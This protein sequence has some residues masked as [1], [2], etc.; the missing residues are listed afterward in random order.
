MNDSPYD[1][2][3]YTC[4]RPD[5][6]FTSGQGSWLTDQNG[7][8]YLDFVQGWAV[9]CLGHS[10]LA[11]T[12]AL[13]C[14]AEKMWNCS[15]AFYNA[16]QIALAQQ[17]TEASG[18]DKAFFAS[19]GAEANEGAIKLARKWGQENK[20]G[21]YKIITMEGSFHG[22]TLATMS[23]TGKPAFTDLFNPKVDGFV[24]VPF[25][26]LAACEQAIDDSVVAILLE[27]V[28]GEA[29]VIPASQAY[30]RGLSA[31]CQRHN[32]LLVFDEVQTG[33][34]R[35]GTVFA[36]DYY[37]VR[38]DVMTLGKGLGGGAPLAV[39]LARESVCCFEPGEQGST[40][41]GNAL[42]CAVGLE[43][44]KTVSR[45]EFLEQ[46][47]FSSS[48]LHHKLSSLFGEGSVR[49]MGLLLAVALELPV[50]NSVV[51][52]CF[53][54]GLLINAPNDQC[55]RFMPAL[56]VTLPEIE[57]MIEILSSAIDS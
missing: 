29:G 43:V 17:L 38:P 25:N 31:L 16:P 23:A 2:I 8:R 44:F 11:L 34:G 37:E 30:I 52:T 36:S 49:G 5:T 10:P 33:I 20:A 22:R 21:A 27:P 51:K 53:G 55:L 12:Q 32:I 9:N 47:Q 26:D 56:N 19:T 54:E 6:V 39:V 42:M 1:S 35:L 18:L 41:G 13:N 57:R 4:D 24:K 28:Q 50:A 14:Q 40:F 7:K 3:M 15:P 48:Y 46:M 45:T